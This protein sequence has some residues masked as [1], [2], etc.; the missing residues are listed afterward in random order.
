MKNSIALA[1]AFSSVILFGCEKKFTP[2]AED[3]SALQAGNFEK[4]ETVDLRRGLMAYYTFSGNTKD[5]SPNKLK[6][7]LINGAKLGTD[8]FNNKR[9]CLQL[10]GIND[11]AI[12]YDRGM[13]NSPTL[14]LACNYFCL[15]SRH[16]Q[17][18]FGRINFNS[19][20]GATYTL[21]VIPD[22]NGGVKDLFH[23][24]NP[25]T[26]CDQQV[27]TN[28]SDYVINPN[29]KPTAEWHNIVG[30]FENGVGKLYSD[31]RLV[32]TQQ[33]SYSEAKVC[34]NTDFLIGAWFQAYIHFRGKIDD[35][36]FYNR[37][38]NRK[39]IKLLADGF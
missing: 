7:F 2:A 16:D 18:L 12:V 39:E 23:A 6:A 1:C 28:Y 15:N 25:V 9:S 35:V 11:Y 3:H 31:G 34:T 27:G 22:N 21:A 14:T 10:D 38:L 37:A 36:R 29:G 13:L 19:G 32:V 30:T 24:L 4:A 26:G 33:F 17:T 20:N 8:R 5:S